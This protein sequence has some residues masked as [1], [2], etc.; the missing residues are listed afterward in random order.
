MGKATAGTGE[1]RE[2]GR[3]VQ[4]SVEA[5]EGIREAIQG[6][7]WA[8]LI[9]T[10][11]G[12]YAFGVISLMAVWF[13]IVGPELKSRAIDLKTHQQIMDQQ[14]DQCVTLERTSGNLKETST[15]QERIVDRL[16]RM[17]YK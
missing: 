15:I 3:T 5:S 1:A 4:S 12:P 14:R 7:N 10:T 11:Y 16:E 17:L 8:K 9:S 2:A 6:M 13:F